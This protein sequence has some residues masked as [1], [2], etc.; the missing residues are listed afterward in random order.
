MGGSLLE[1]TGSYTTIVSTEALAA[2]LE[3]PAWVIVDCRFDL[4][5]PEWGQ[6][7]YLQGHIPGALYAHLDRDL[8]GPKTA[9]TGRHPLPEPEMWSQTLSALGVE[10]GTQVIAYDTT[11][12]SY[13]ARLWWMLR[14]MGHDGVAVL[15]GG[16]ARWQRDGNPVRGGVETSTPANF[17]GAPRPGW[18]LTVDEV[19]AGLRN[20]DRLLVDQAT[21][22][23][24]RQIN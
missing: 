17:R 1:I 15:D 14:W 13:A 7:D 16:F 11:G 4:Q 19:E 9:E 20:P 18:R 8:S 5:N 24:H 21:A 2:H 12:G 6:Q 22:S 3:D 10:P 23:S